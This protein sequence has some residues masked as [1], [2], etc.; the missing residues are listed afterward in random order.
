MMSIIP[1]ANLVFVTNWKYIGTKINF[2]K[3]TRGKEMQ[4]EHSILTPETED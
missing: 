3:F 1:A 4:D 2:Y